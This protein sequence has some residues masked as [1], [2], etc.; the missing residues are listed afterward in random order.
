MLGLATF[1]LKENPVICSKI[2]EF[3]N[4]ND[5]EGTY[6]YEYMHNRLPDR[7]KKYFSEYEIPA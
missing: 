5:D 4:D 2:L 6:P 7:M 3:A 1:H